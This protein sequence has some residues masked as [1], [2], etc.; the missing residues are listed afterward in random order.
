MWASQQQSWVCTDTLPSAVPAVP[1]VSGSTQICSLSARPLNSSPLTPFLSIIHYFYFSAEYMETLQS[2]WRPRSRASSLQITARE[3]SERLEM[4]HE[5]NI[6]VRYK[7]LVWAPSIITLYTCLKYEGEK[8][9][10]LLAVKQ[11]VTLDM[12]SN[13][14]TSCSSVFSLWLSD[15]SLHLHTLCLLF[16]SV[17]DSGNFSEWPPTSHHLS[18]PVQPWRCCMR[19]WY[20]VFQLHLQERDRR[21]KVLTKNCKL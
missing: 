15:S 16:I 19:N 8:Q 13:N 18:L 9:A 21:K 7:E 2:H 11:L 3:E 10:S 20:L 12:Y 6:I 4:H 1:Q 14:W 17:Q 5:K